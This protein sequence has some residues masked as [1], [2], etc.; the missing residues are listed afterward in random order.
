MSDKYEIDSVIICDDFRTEVTGKQIL[1]GVYTDVLVFTTLPTQIMRLTVRIQARSSEKLAKLKFQLKN[2]DNGI[3]ATVE[4][5]LPEYDPT[6]PFLL[7]MTLAGLILAAGT[8]TVEL[9]LDCDPEKIHEFVVRLPKNDEEKQ[10]VPQ[11]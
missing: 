4:G 6:E 10:R 2:P 7:N 9:G 3:N 8:Y 5:D 1:I 11:Y